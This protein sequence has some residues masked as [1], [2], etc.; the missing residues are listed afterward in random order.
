MFEEGCAVNYFYPS[1]R[2]PVLLLLLA[3]CLLWVM[4]AKK[5]H[6]AVSCSATMT[7]V[8]FGPN[9]DL[10]AGV[11]LIAS[12]TLNYTCTNDADS[13]TNVP[14]CFNIGDGI[15]SLRFF[16]LRRTKIRTSILQFQISIPQQA[17][18]GGL[19]ATARCH[20]LFPPIFRFQE[21]PVASTEASLV[22]PT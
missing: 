6:A 19:R 16:N 13:A 15:E 8:D 5:V 22:R 20:S 14:V 17:L 3:C 12:G 2:S 9:G 18:L 7:T 4:P 21:E 11:G 10:I 1:S